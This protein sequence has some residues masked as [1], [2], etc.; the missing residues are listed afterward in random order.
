M[1]RFEQPLREAES[2]ARRVLG[3]RRQAGGDIGLDFVG[4]GVVLASLED[5]RL[6]RRGH[7]EHDHRRRERLLQIGPLLV[8]VGPLF[9]ETLIVGT[10]LIA[11]PFVLFLSGAA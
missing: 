9:D 6:A 8:S 11:V 10:S 7:F 3:E 4:R 2:I 1:V 5:E